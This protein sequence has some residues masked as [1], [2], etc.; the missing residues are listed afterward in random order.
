[1]T[2]GK[3]KTANLPVDYPEVCV[4]MGVLGCLSALS[5]CVAR[6][7]YK[8]GND[9]LLEMAHYADYTHRFGLVLPCS[10][11]DFEKIRLPEGSFLQVR[12]TFTFWKWYTW[13]QDYLCGM[14]PFSRACLNRFAEQKEWDKVR[15]YRPPADWIYVLDPY[16]HP[17][18]EKLAGN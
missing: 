5:D 11:Q 14:D 3:S 9:A 7:D 4:W 12:F 6:Q 2:Q 13:W 1:M 18:I 15:K 10:I 17:V 16:V 8:K